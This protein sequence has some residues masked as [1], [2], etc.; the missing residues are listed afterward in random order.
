HLREACFGR[1]R[2]HGL[3]ERVRGQLALNVA[4][5]LAVIGDAV[6]E[7]D[8]HD[9]LVLVVVAERESPGREPDQE[10]EQEHPDQDGHRRRGGRGDVREQ[11]A[12]RLGQQ[13]LES[14]HYE[15]YPPRRSS[16]ASRPSSSAITLRRI[17]STISRSCVAITT[18]VPARLIR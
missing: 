15:A 2:R 9:E 13:E 12:D 6:V 17:L 16:R 10:A 11:R 8:L 14:S 5:F 4:D 1:D 3:D 18:V 7:V